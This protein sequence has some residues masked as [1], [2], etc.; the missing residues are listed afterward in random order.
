MPFS[1]LRDKDGR[2]LEER[3]TVRL[4]TR[5]EAL[6]G[7]TENQTLPVAGRAVLAGGLDYAR[8]DEKGAA[9]LPGTLRRS[10][11]SAHF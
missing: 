11:L 10:A 4:L 3:Y 6:Y 9:P 8:N 7:I 1:L 2:L 5:P